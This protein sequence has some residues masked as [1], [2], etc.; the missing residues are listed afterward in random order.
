VDGE[1]VPCLV[2]WLFGGWWRADFY[3]HFCNYHPLKNF[4][5]LK[6]EFDM[7]TVKQCDRC[8]QEAVA[9]VTVTSTVTTK[10]ESDLCADCLVEF[11]LFLHWLTGQYNENA[12]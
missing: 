6:K 11:K 9:S 3:R 7:A 5:P 8:G 2:D 1:V 12:E 10:V 4:Y